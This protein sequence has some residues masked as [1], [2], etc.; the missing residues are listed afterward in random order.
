MSGVP[1][2]T[3]ADA[4]SL[5]SRLFGLDASACPLPSERDQNLLLRAADGAEIKGEV[6]GTIN[7]VPKE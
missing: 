3:T 5:A 6:N 7:R 1:G 2:I 4:T